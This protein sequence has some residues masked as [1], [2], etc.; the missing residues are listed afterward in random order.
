MRIFI[1]YGYNERDAWIEKHVFPILHAMN[2]ETADGKDAHGEE[3]QQTVKDRINQSDAIIGFCTL[4]QGQEAA[5][6]NTHV[7]VRDE[8]SYALGARM[9]CVEVR[10]KGVNTLLGLLGDRQYIAL[11]PGDKLSCV[12]ELVKAVAGWSMRRLL[13]CPSEPPQAR[14]ILKA[15]TARTL[16]VQYRARVNGLVKQPRDGRLVKENMGL[17]LDAVGLPSGSF[18]EVE[19]S[20]ASDGVL[21]NTGWVSADLV[22][23][24]F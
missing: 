21:F 2:I 9:P 5:E 18:V 16:Q 10:E 19:G 14:R 11:D 3:L 8:L 23:I 4:R 6:M 12:T 1:G 13:L 20:T 7:W 17:Y 15:L 22:R 24:E